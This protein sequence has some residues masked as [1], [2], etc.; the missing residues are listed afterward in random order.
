MKTRQAVL[1]K[2]RRFEIQQ[3][4]V[5]LGEGQILVETAG[6]GLCTYELNHWAGRLGTPP[7][8]LG[9]EGYGVVVEVGPGTTGRVKAGDRV[10]G[11]CGK[12]FS[13]YFTM[14]ERHVMLIRPDL[15]QQ[16][17]P[18]E[19]LYCVHN[20]VRAAHPEIGDCLAIVGCGPMGLW[21]LQALASPT[22]AAV[23]AVDVDDEKLDLAKLYGATHSINPG[24]CDAVEAMKEI[25]A[26]RLAD[27]VV[28]A[29]GAAAGM[30]T[31]IHLLRPRRP[32]LVVCSSFEGPIQLNVPALLAKAV[33][34]LHAHPGICMDREDGCRRTETLINHG[35][36]RTDRL[37]SHRF[38]LEDVQKAFETFENRGKGYLKGI[39]TR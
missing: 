23:V 5:A 7:M 25:T 16:H 39:V 10:T 3:A 9:H 20:V 38:P 33:D 31:A 29:T 32:R 4:D 8:A 35:V 18:G 26:G 1:V 13:D 34:V 19:P 30:E 17:V 15:D 27:V 2:P 21:S 6:C 37:I 24:K 28:E 22:L 14:P 11:L 36:F 12:C